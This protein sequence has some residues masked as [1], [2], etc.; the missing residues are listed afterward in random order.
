[1][2]GRQVKMQRARRMGDTGTDNGWPYVTS[3]GLPACIPG[4]VVR[5]REEEGRAVGGRCECSAGAIR[6]FWV[7]VGPMDSKAS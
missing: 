7:G 4:F 2:Y 1:M 6:S 3:G 5:G